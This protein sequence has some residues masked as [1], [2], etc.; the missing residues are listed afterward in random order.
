M[1]SVD[2]NAYI[3]GQLD[4]PYQWRC[5]MM[6]VFK[7]LLSALN[8]SVLSHLPKLT[9]PFLKDPLRLSFFI[10]NSVSLLIA[11]LM[12]NAAA[13]ALFKDVALARFSTVVF[14]ITVYFIFIL[15]PNLPYI[16]P[17]DIPSL[18]FG[19]LGAWLVLS[20]RYMWA[21]V[22]L[23]LAVM[24]RE[25]AFMTPML[26]LCLL[27]RGH[28]KKPGWLY[29]IAMGAMWVAVKLLLVQMFIHNGDASEFKLP[30][31][32]ATVVK[33]WQWP[34]LLPVFTMFVVSV[35]ASLL[36]GRINAVGMATAIGFAALFIV[37]AIV[38]TRAFGDLIQ[39]AALCMTHLLA[40]QLHK[41]KPHAINQ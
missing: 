3:A 9:P 33:P 1:D 34:A 17:Y 36:P 6:P 39:L 20:G 41:T 22:M 5:L 37:A 4:T 15:N 32:L 30:H 19:G 27:L 35:R 24:N 14:T 29:L 12:H 38:E 10:V 7:F 23:P 26:L 31:N 18:A 21:L 11:M 13:R 40:M 8:P 16:L 2:M 28:A 25:T